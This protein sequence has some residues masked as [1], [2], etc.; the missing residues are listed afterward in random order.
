MGDSKE[1][2]LCNE[3]LKP[4]AIDSLMETSEW[5]PRRTMMIGDGRQDDREE[6]N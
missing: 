3:I 1:M 2:S 5:V 6:K 4:Q